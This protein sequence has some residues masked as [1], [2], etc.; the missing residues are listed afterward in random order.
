MKKIINGKKYDT[1]TAKR[2]GCWSNNYN[3]GD[4]NWCAERLYKKKNGEFFLHG[5]GGAMSIYSRSFGQNEWRGGESIR[6]LTESEAKLWAEK[7]LDG[8]E[9]E[10]IFGEVEE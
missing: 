8:D 6:P 10:S 9:Y 3:W 4:F 7:H 5:E 2:V 1:E